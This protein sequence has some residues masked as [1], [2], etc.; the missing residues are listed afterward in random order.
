MTRQEARADKV[1]SKS[2]RNK[3]SPSSITRRNHI[4]PELRHTTCNTRRTM[5]LLMAA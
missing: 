4:G 3:S 1:T 2:R 5:F